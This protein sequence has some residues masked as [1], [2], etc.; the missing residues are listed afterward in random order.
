MNSGA[1]LS[2]FSLCIPFAQDSSTMITHLRQGKRLPRTPWFGSDDVARAFTLKKDVFAARLNHD[3]AD[4]DA[5]VCQLVDDA[6]AHAGLPAQS[7]SGARVRAY[8]TGLGPRVDTLDYG[9]FFDHNAIEDVKLKKSVTR[10]HATNIAQD[11]LAHRVAKQ[12]DL[13]V[14]PPCL[15]C[16]SNSSLA[17][18][19]LGIQ[20]IGSGEIDLVLVINCSELKTQDLAFLDAQSMLEGEHIQPFCEE[21]RCVLPS[22]GFSALLLESERYRAARNAGKGIRL[23]CDYLQM[24]ASRTNDASQLTSS[25]LKVMGSTLARAEVDVDALCAVIPHANG[26]GVSDKA[27]AQALSSLL[28]DT[29]VPVLAYKG[30]MGYVTTGSGIIDMVIGHHCLTEGELLSPSGSGNIRSNISGRFLL[31]QGVVLHEK[32]HLLK[33]GLGVD[34]SVIGLLMSAEH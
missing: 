8:I 26:S 27:E 21:S 22:E 19:H 12:Y 17:A 25:L 14:M 24:S 18:V 11:R 3:F 20:A 6:L 30:Q 28:S 1:I 5:L 7:L 4:G 33:V 13:Q 2:G 34:G 31:N 10:L 23:V 29:T 32:R 15:H 9:S 16:S